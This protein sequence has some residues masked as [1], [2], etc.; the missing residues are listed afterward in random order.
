MTT[1]ELQTPER[2]ITESTGTRLI[3]SISELN[4]SMAVANTRLQD[5]AIKFDRQELLNN[6]VEKRLKER[7]IAAVEIVQYVDARKAA[8]DLQAMAHEARIKTVE[9]W[10]K[11]VNGILIAA[12]TA[13]FIA[14]VMGVLYLVFGAKIP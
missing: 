4:T 3:A 8:N 1:R 14:I 13:V 2:T 5:I 7:E 10:K 11:G 6:D 9:D 12:G